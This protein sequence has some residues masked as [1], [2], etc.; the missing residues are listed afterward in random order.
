VGCNLV[1]RGSREATKSKQ[2]NPQASING[3]CE[4]NKRAEPWFG[5]GPRRL[6]RRSFGVVRSEVEKRS[7][8][9]AVAIRYTRLGA[10]NGRALFSSE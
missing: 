8:V 2:G 5:A 1:G 7:E 6:V 4:A 3:M 9:G 10:S